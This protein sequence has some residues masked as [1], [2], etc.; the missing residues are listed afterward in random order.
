MTKEEF[1]IQ[2]QVYYYKQEGIENWF[3]FLDD[4]VK[5][6]IVKDTTEECCH[7][8]NN[9]Y[10]WLIDTKNDEFIKSYYNALIIYGEDE[11]EESEFVALPLH[12]KLDYYVQLK[13]TYVEDD[14][15]EDFATH[16]IVD[17]MI[18]YKA[19]WRDEQIESIFRDED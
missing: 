12:L 16:W 9:E 18:L 19:D 3:K 7:L 1:I 11:L 15:L 14:C 5:V 4:D 8:S 6:A 2:A 17:L 13:K 10:L